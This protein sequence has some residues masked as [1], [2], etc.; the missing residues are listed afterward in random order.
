MIDRQVE[1]QCDPAD[2]PADAR[3]KDHVDVIVQ[4]LVLRTDNVRFHCER[5]AAASTGTTYQAPLP[6]G[7]AG[8]FGP[9]LQALALTL[10]YNEQCGPGQIP[11]CSPVW[12]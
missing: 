4:D 12:G 9:G 6:P 3:L 5:W 7:Y 11:S 10:A 1:C 8:E 2:L